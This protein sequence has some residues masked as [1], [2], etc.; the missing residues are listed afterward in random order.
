[1][2][3]SISGMLE[4]GELVDRGINNPEPLIKVLVGCLSTCKV[5]YMDVADRSSICILSPKVTSH[6]EL[7]AIASCQAVQ[8]QVQ[9]QE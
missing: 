5:D 3:L 6:S 4:A 8:R 7:L 9:L 1:M 2:L